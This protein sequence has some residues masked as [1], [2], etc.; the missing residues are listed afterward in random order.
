MGW[1]QQHLPTFLFRRSIGREE[2]SQAAVDLV[3]IQRVRVEPVPWTGHAGH[4]FAHV[5]MIFMRGV[6]ERDQQLLIAVNPTL[7]SLMG[8]G[9]PEAGCQA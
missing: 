2:F 5:V 7:I 3:D 6:R 9:K 1:G 4:P 8:S